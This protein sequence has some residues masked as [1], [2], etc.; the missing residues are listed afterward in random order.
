[1]SNIDEIP[2][3]ANWQFGKIIVLVHFI[4]QILKFFKIEKCAFVSVS[5]V[6]GKSERIERKFKT[7]K[8]SQS[9]RLGGLCV[10]MGL[11]VQFKSP[12]SILI[13][14]AVASR[15]TVCYTMVTV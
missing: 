1:M 15:A 14:A 3:K 2:K 5:L 9:V 11:L 4:T 8:S 6:R 10:L 13:V 7:E 12:L